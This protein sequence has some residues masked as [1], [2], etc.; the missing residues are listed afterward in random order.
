ML[1]TF[2]RKKSSDTTSWKHLCGYV[3]KTWNGYLFRFTRKTTGT[4]SFNRSRM[5]SNMTSATPDSLPEV[6]SEVAG[7]Y[8]HNMRRDRPY[9]GQPW[10]TAGARGRLQVQGITTRDLKDCFIRA[11]LS[12]TGG[13]V[14][15][16]D[17]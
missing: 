4:N 6:I 10:T 2:L 7:D 5:R 16:P 17:P 11:I 8:E 12:A 13:S 15:F 3:V 1:E 9:N 14:S